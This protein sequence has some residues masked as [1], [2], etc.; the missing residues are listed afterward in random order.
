MKNVWQQKFTFFFVPMEIYAVIHDSTL[1]AI[2][3]YNFYNKP[4]NPFQT[5]TSQKIAN[6]AILAIIAEIAKI[7]KIAKI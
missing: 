1:K 4:E 2:M 6:F 3:S 7:A 5:V